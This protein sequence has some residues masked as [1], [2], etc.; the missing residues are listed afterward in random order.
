MP[1]NKQNNT[2]YNKN[3]TINDMYQKKKHKMLQQWVCRHSFKYLIKL[4]VI[5]SHHFPFIKPFLQSFILA[6]N[7][8]SIK[9]CIRY[10][11]Q[12]GF[13][14][15]H[16]KDKLQQNNTNGKQKIINET[17][18]IIYTIKTKQ[19]KTHKDICLFNTNMTIRQ[20]QKTKNKQ[21]NK[22]Q[23]LTTMIGNKNKTCKY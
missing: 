15:D 17:I 7:Y 4:L 23:N 19:T 10:Y 9:K 22:C 11:S 13:T 3:K 16:D 1:T 20:Q 21:T 6:L 12:I 2:K 14:F 18:I 5:K 8:A